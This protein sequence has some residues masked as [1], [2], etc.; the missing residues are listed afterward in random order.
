M[1]VFSHVIAFL[2]LAEN[3][4]FPKKSSVLRE[5]CYFLL[6]THQMITFYYL[7]KVA[8]VMSAFCGLMREELAKLRINNIEDR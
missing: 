4:T 1:Y 7:H 3:D 6:K 2:K 5:K 8:S